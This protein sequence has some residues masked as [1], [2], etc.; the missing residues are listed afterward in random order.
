MLN[1]S[2]ARPY[3]RESRWTHKIRHCALGAESRSWILLRGQGGQDKAYAARR[4][5]LE[6]AERRKLAGPR[7]T[8]GTERAP[9]SSRFVLTVENR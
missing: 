7:R 9:Q 8:R 5:K 3:V 6:K 1:T 4:A 2:G